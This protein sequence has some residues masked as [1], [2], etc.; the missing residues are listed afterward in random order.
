MAPFRFN[1]VWIRAD[2]AGSKKLPGVDKEALEGLAKQFP[3][4][5]ASS[6]NDDKPGSPEADEKPAQRK[7]QDMAAAETPRGGAKSK[8]P[9]PS[10]PKADAAPVTSPV[11][12]PVTT[13]DMTGDDATASTPKPDGQPKTGSA[14][15]AATAGTAGAAGAKAPQTSSPSSSPAPPQKST[16]PSPVPREPRRGGRALAT[17]SLLISLCALAFAAAALSPPQLRDW[18]QARIDYP[19]L[20]DFLTGTRAGM[21]A[22]LQTDAAAIQ[23]VENNL[24]THDARLEAIE[25]VGGSNK[26]A[27][28]RVDAVETLAGVGEQ[29]VRSLDATVAG[30]AQRLDTAAKQDVE[31]GQRLAALENQVPGRLTEIEAGLGALKRSS[32]GPAKLYLIALRLRIAAQSSAPFADEVAAATLVGINGGP[33]AAALQLLGRH[34]VDGVATRAQLHDRFRRQLAPRLRGATDG[35]GR[36]LFV[37]FRSWF[38][39]LFLDERGTPMAFA[40]AA[41]IVALAE[42]ALAR[43]QLRAASDHLERLDGPFAATVAPWLNQ[44]RARVAVDTATAS[45]MTEA[46]DSFVAMDD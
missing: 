23:S 32:S 6:S 40:N 1:R 11:T 41:A 30:F 8:S 2:M 25:A 10:A 3:R 5:Q 46:F 35:A 15:P 18:L 44:A 20:V 7:E 19:P 13:G 17:L 24:A 45:L 38:N 26:A 33:I 39:S 34:A 36:S 14:A 31:M 28:R 12:S 27:A 9:A 42:D 37:Q 43:D 16:P 22:R 4:S 21:E 29:N